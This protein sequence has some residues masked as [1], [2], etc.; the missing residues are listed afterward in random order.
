VTD[1]RTLPTLGRHN[2]HL[3]RLRRIV[4][5][6][7]ADLT[8]AE[9]LKLTADL[10]AAGTPIVEL[11]TIPDR[12][13][14]VLGS[15]ELSKVCNEGRAYLVEPATASGI[16]P[17]QQTQGVI[18]VVPV[19]AVRLRAE[20]IV[21]YLDR[22]QDPGNVGSVVRCAAAFGASGVACSPGCADPFS[23]RAVRASAGNALLLPV[24]AAAA[25]GPLA[26]E[27]RRAGGEVAATSGR[28]GIAPG[29]WRPRRPLVLA[30]GNEGQGL[31]DEIL[32][33]CR[34]TVTIPLSEGVESLN[35]AVTAGILL[36]SLAG[37]AGPP[38]LGL[39]GREGRPR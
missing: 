16:A 19:P 20:G 14:E 5:R 30:L 13:P 37:V 9:G 34:R 18:A 35:V 24:Q 10:A 36:A 3:L 33:V 17:T 28:G 39:Q 6:Q 15:R 2:P 38:I 25:F 31:S 27:A 12:L 8:V 22:V 29:R 32:A 21:V 26:E 11:F 4:Q 7:E 1:S 23:P